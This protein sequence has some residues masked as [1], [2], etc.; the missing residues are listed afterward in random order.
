M[1]LHAAEIPEL[2]SKSHVAWMKPCDENELYSSLVYRNCPPFYNGYCWMRLPNS[3][4]LSDSY[5]CLWL[6]VIGSDNGLAPD[7]RQAIIWTNAG[8]LSL[9]HLGTNFSEI[10]I[11]I[12]ALAFKK[13]HLKIPSA[14]SRPSCLTINVL[15]HTFCYC[16]QNSP[17]R[18]LQRVQMIR[19]NS[20]DHTL[21][22]PVNLTPSMGSERTV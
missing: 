15:K 22:T 12:L 3:L 20:L 11:E 5:M 18:L 14:K 9:G 10:V 2:Y 13:M 7:R 1:R 17:R 6:S 16:I 8:M 21:L 19:R 4:R